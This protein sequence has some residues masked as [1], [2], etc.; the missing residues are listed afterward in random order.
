MILRITSTGD[1]T[2]RADPSYVAV[3]ILPRSFK[4]SGT[5]ASLVY[6]LELAE[7]HLNRGPGDFTQCG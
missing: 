2:I 4:V 7:W 6:H 1:L 5:E 3:G